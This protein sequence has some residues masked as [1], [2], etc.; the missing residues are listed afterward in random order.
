M[1]SEKRKSPRGPDTSYPGSGGEVSSEVE[2]LLNRAPQFHA[3]AEIAKGRIPELSASQQ[4]FLRKF[5]S[6]LTAEATKDDDTS[7]STPTA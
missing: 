3:L 5:S 4:E 1:T 7:T 6:Q 2:N